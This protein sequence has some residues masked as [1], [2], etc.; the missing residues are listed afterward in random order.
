[1]NLNE[2]RDNAGSRYRKKRLGRGIGSGKGKTSGKGVKGQKAREGVSL[3]GFEGGQ[4]PLYRRLPKR[5]FKNIFRKEY[6]PVNLG[7]LDKAIADGKI[8]AGTVVTE[9]VLRT[10]GL[11]G[12]GKFAGVRLLAKGELARAV[13]IEVSGASATAVAAVEKAGGSVRTKA[14]RDEAQAPA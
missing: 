3:N 2:L 5:G 13:T 6:A 11:V 12:S 9:D 7:A 14:A 10:A 4:L 1:M 8:D